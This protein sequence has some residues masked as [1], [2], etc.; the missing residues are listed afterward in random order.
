MTN[1]GSQ[2]PS[3]ESQVEPHSYPNVQPSTDLPSISQRSTAQV[4]K[5]GAMAPE[6]EQ[7]AAGDGRTPYPDVRF[8]IEMVSGMVDKA[9]MRERARAITVPLLPS[10][11]TFSTPL[12][13]PW[14]KRGKGTGEGEGARAGRRRKIFFS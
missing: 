11:C 8:E 10:L 7:P 5:A 1:E 9:A 4:A 3:S 14:G 6:A 13:P 12:P 2:V